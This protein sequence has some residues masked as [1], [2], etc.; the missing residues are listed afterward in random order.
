MVAQAE[1]TQKLALANYCL[2][3]W[4]LRA[5]ALKVYEINSANEF[6]NMRNEWNTLL[7]RTNDNTLFLSWERMAP[8]IKYL[9]P[10]SKL[11]ILYATDGKE[12]LGIAPLRKSNRCF[13]GHSICSTIEVIS[14]RAPGILLSKRKAECLNK[15]LTYLYDQ[16][17]WDFL[18]FNEVPETFS[19]VYL[20]RKSA[21]SIPDMEVIEGDVS[22]HLTIPGSL[23]EF[24]RGLTRSYRKHLRRQMRR[25]EGEHGRIELKDYYELGSL[26]EMMQVFFNIHQKRWISKGGPGVFKTK[27]NRD[28]FLYEAQLF[29][30]INCLRLRFLMVNDKPIAVFYGFEHDQVLYYLLSGF[31]PAYASYSPGNLLELK[32]IE[33]CV[34]EGI[35]ELNFFGGYTRHKFRWCNEYRRN[36][37]FR[38]VN[39]KFRSRTLNL[40]M[41]L[42]TS[43]CLRN[44]FLR[45]FI[46]F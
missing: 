43:T 39:R 46:L 45:S 23:D 7:K 1:K 21:Q 31:D 42:L 41:H 19:A 6:Y 25:I 15:F 11:S 13:N 16:K 28:M 32:T 5:R 12:I 35:K 37:T 44:L 18:Y 20:L 26:E 10:G 9:N 34:E 3:K 8:G 40:G 30:E 2:V 38:F 36:F 4:R 14:L 27:R 24:Y 22:P 17:D 29:S 33:K